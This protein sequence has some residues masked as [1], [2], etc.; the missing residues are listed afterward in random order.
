MSI[1][2]SKNLKQSQSVRLTPSLKKSIDLLQLSRFE[3]IRKIEN[4]IIEN[5]FLENEKNDHNPVDFGEFDFD[6]ESKLS[7]RES[8][9]RQ[10][11]DFHLNNREMKISKLIIDC[12]D[13]S[14]ELV[15]SIEQIEEISNFNFT[16]IEIK[17]N[18]ENIIHKLNP[19]GVGYRN[20]KECIKIQID[21]NINISLNNRELINIILL[22][23]ELDNLSQIKKLVLQNGFS[24]N[25][26]SSA[27]DIIKN[28]DLSPGLNY[29][30]TQYIEADLKILIKNK[31]LKV[32]FKEEGFPIIRLDDKLIGDVKKE[33]KLKK[34]TQILQ[35]INDAKWLLKS[36]KKRN[37]TVQKVGEYICSKQIAF[38][39]DN[40]LKIN[41][42]SNK[43]IA[44][45]IAVHPSTVS[46]ILR[47]KYI[48]TPKG[49]MP[50]K[51]LLI[52]SVSKTR[53]ISATQLMKLIESIVSAEK[54]PKSDK[55]I[56]IELNKRGFSLARRTISKYRK[57]NN[58]PS[59][60]YR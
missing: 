28:C 13:E 45:K 59:S 36:V 42:L 35:K 16:H 2:L 20:H 17:E 4:E 55:K 44:D 34:N 47:N 37:E 14:G 18:L 38:F 48:D 40:P 58:I 12:I 43:E 53:D 57:K 27:L 26:F 15:E 30:N 9:I 24:D 19:S 31:A 10:L 29:E 39:E 56:A 52:S 50:L 41:T 5:P 49:M 8:L 22:N 1:R 11:D 3:L 21:N 32:S 6:I 23:D 46:R 25:D 60:R 54:K 33:L 51:S 7:L